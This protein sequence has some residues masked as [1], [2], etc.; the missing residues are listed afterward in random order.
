MKNYS[1]LKKRIYQVG[2]LLF[3]LQCIYPILSSIGMRYIL[4]KIN[5]DA[6]QSIVRINYFFA[7]SLS[8]IYALILVFISV[9]EFKDFGS[10]RVKRLSLINVCL[11]FSHILIRVGSS[12]Y[13][14]YISV[15]KLPILSAGISFIRTVAI[16]SFLNQ[17]ISVILHLI[18]LALMIISYRSNVEY[19]KTGYRQN[20]T[21]V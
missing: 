16:V 4:E 10:S 19:N 20:E 12:I 7:L 9:M 15:Q 1:H 14:Y 17:G 2:F 5:P 3:A 21:L 8:I 13:V 6:A 11:A 18:I